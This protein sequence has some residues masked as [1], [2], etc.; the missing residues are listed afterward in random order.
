MFSSGSRWKCAYSKIWARP[1]TVILGIR[2][3]VES[4]TANGTTVA[5]GMKVAP[6]GSSK[7]IL[8]GVDYIRRIYSGSLD[9][10]LS[11]FRS[12]CSP[13]LPLPNLVPRTDSC[14]TS[15]GTSTSS[16]AHQRS[17]PAGIRRNTW[18]SAIGVDSPLDVRSGHF[19][20][21]NVACL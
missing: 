3:I 21:P 8:Q 19:G 9:N 12:H 7:A 14:L 4:V 10:P 11:T 20:G 16:S 6:A 2:I 15:D 1:Q 13:F 18:R 5:A 17:S